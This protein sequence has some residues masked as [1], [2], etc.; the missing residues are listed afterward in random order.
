[1]LNERRDDSKVL[2]KL[3]QIRRECEDGHK[4]SNAKLAETNT[5]LAIAAEKIASIET[6]QRDSLSAYREHDRMIAV[7]ES[8]HNDFEK[9]KDQIFDMIGKDRKEFRGLKSPAMAAGAISPDSIKWIVAGVLGSIVLMLIA[10]GAITA[11]D[12]KEVIG[13]AK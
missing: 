13:A 6:I 4:E 7:H 5:H 12:A 3:E 8:R 2:D 9:D 11:N 10:F 1:M